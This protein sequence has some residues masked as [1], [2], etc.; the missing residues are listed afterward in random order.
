LGQC[1]SLTQKNKIKIKI[2]GV[3]RNCIF[4]TVPPCMIAASLDYKTA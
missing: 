2:P 3:R 4:P 1:D